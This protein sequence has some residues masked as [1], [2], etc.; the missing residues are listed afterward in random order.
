MPKVN[1]SYLFANRL[2]KRKSKLVT[3]PSLGC[4][5]IIHQKHGHNVLGSLLNK[6]EA[7]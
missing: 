7:R 6:K 3:S 5:N 2:A 1:C 4:N